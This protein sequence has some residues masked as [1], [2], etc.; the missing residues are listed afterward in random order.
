MTLA[1][2][3]WWSDLPR[4]KLGIGADLVDMLLGLVLAGEKTACCGPPHLYP[5]GAPKA[6]DRCVLVD[7]TDRPRCVIEDEE[8]IVQRFDEVSEAFAL[9]EG[10]G[11]YAEWRAAHERFFAEHGGLSPDMLVICERFK[12]LEVIQP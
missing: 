4:D 12:V 8:V 9:L 7:S 2:K 10:E 11:D 5:N 1:S 3:P 6:G